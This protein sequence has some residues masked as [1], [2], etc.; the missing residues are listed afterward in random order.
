M[1]MGAP[2]RGVTTSTIGPLRETRYAG[3]CCTGVGSTRPMRRSTRSAASRRVEKFDGGADS[4]M[5]TT[6][7]FSIED[8]LGWGRIAFG[9]GKCGEKTKT[10]TELDTRHTSAPA[11]SSTPGSLFHHG[12][13]HADSRCCYSSCVCVIR[14]NGFVRPNGCWGRASARKRLY[15]S[16]VGN[17]FPRRSGSYD[18]RNVKG[19]ARL[20]LAVEFECCVMF[21]CRVGRSAGPCRERGYKGASDASRVPD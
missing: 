5:H 21:Y 12:T 13:T 10:R 8:G 14:H 15:P 20:L 17:G 6:Q 3:Y 16:N 1:G 7:R 19:N 2:R 11:R 9:R 18:W 4:D